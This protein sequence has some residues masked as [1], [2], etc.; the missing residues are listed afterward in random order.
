MLRLSQHTGPFCSCYSFYNDF[1][2][3]CMGAEK[4]A[5]AW[6]LRQPLSPVECSFNPLA[7]RSLGDAFL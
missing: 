4:K 1:Y 2:I 6:G 3:V 5:M 7:P